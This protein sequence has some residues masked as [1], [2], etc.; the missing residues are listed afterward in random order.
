MSSDDRDEERRRPS[1]DE[2][3]PRRSEFPLFL[4]GEDPS[5]RSRSLS[6]LPQ[7]S[8]AQNAPLDGWERDTPELV[9]RTP[10]LPPP[11]LEEDEEGDALSLVDTRSRP[12][13]AGLDIAQEM[14]DRFELGDY[15]AALRAA[16]L[17]LGHDP[18]N[19]EATSVSAECRER[20]AGIFV[21]RL[22]PLERVPRAAV[23]PENVRWLGLDHRAG[24]LFSLVDG[25]NSFETIVD[26]CPMPRLE[27][28]KTLV[29][30]LD[31]GAVELP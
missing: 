30:L 21:A 15:T 16:E 14:R 20:L 1:A 26:I 3:T 8:A 19:A 2:L 12:S 27:A 18:N 31:M 10:S 24:F 4:P 23:A 22:G 13:T 6:P 11:V 17:L 5:G 28:L 29:E 9:P 25:E 7:R